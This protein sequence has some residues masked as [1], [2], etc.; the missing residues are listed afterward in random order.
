MGKVKFNRL[1][2]VFAEHEIKSVEVAKLLEVST[3]TVSNW[4][5]NKTQPNAKDFLKI[6]EHLDVDVRT[7]INSSKG[8]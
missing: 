4:V 2:V 1:K 5:N 7:L 8:V 3:N 6:A